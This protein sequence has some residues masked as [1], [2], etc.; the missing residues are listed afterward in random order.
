[1]TYLYIYI[2]IIF[3]K[4]VIYIVVISVLSL[5]VKFSS[6]NRNNY[7]LG[8]YESTFLGKTDIEFVSK[9]KERKKETF[10]TF[11]S[12]RSQPTSVIVWST[13]VSTAW[14]TCMCDGTIEAKAYIG[15][16][17]RHMLTSELCL[18]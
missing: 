13:L 10:Q 4:V 18:G 9:K 12:D 8:S 6:K 5:S 17:Q 7:V 14:V 1:M 2:I 3:L 15:S 11:V 16:A